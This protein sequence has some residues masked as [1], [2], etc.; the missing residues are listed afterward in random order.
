MHIIFFA[1]CFVVKGKFCRALITCKAW[2]SE[3]T[4]QSFLKCSQ[5]SGFLF[6]ESI[7]FR[8]CLTKFILIITYDLETSMSFS[9]ILCQ[10]SEKYTFMQID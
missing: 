4:I 9:F 3:H 7:N 2:V 1:S 5:I 8:H 6:V 10:S